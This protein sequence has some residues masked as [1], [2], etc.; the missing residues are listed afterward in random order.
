MDGLSLFGTAD[1][2]EDTPLEKVSPSPVQFD[3]D[4][5]IKDIIP[6]V[7][8]NLDQLGTNDPSTLSADPVPNPLI[9]SRELT[10]GM[11][12]QK[13]ARVMDLSRKTGLPARIVEQHLD[14]MERRE[15]LSD[16][17]LDQI[18]NQSPKTAALLSD[19]NFFAV[20]QDD[21]DRIAAL[22]GTISQYNPG[23][24]ERIAAKWE[25]SV[26]QL[27]DGI[28][29]F[30][31]GSLSSYVAMADLGEA[32]GYKPMGLDKVLRGLAREALV[33]VQA[34]HVGGGEAGCGSSSGGRIPAAV[35]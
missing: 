24:F 34:K 12:P 7:Q 4:A 35:S 19:P 29:G 13:T 20:A 5:E 11:D 23:F 6:A 25:D 30:A 1:F 21:I 15:F 32:D 17:K 18:Q 8:P 2:R 10:H 14:E 16:E 22:E 26:Q 9:N 3:P 28:R 33:H 31:L 27:D